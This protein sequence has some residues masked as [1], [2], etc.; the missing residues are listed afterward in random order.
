MSP[1]KGGKYFVKA[2]PGASSVRSE[3]NYPNSLGFEDSGMS[4]L[5]VGSVA[6]LSVCS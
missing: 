4:T 1:K 2:K 5:L 3:S 6:I